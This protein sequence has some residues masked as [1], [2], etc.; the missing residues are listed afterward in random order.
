VFERKENTQTIVDA[1]CCQLVNWSGI[2]PYLKEQLVKVKSSLNDLRRRN[3]QVSTSQMHQ[4]HSTQDSYEERMAA[5]DAFQSLSAYD[6]KMNVEATLAAT[7]NAFQMNVIIF[8]G[9]DLQGYEYYEHLF[10]LTQACIF[11]ICEGGKQYPNVHW[12][13]LKQSAV[14]LL[15][16]DAQDDAQDDAHQDDTPPDDHAQYDARFDAPF[17]TQSGHD[18]SYE[19]LFLD[20]FTDDDDVAVVAGLNGGL[21]V[22]AGLDV[23]V[24]AGLDVAVVGGLDVAAVVDGLDGGVNLINPDNLGVEIDRHAMKYDAGDSAF[25]QDVKLKLQTEFFESR[26]EQ[27]FDQDQD[28]YVCS[29]SKLLY[30]DLGQFSNAAKD[31]IWETCI[32]LNKELEDVILHMVDDNGPSKKLR[33]FHEFYNDKVLGIKIP[34]GF[35]ITQPDLNPANIHPGK[36]ALNEAEACEKRLENKKRSLEEQISTTIDQI[37]LLPPF[38]ALIFENMKPTKVPTLPRKHHEPLPQGEQFDLVALGYADVED[39]PLTAAVYSSDLSSIENIPFFRIEPLGD[40][41]EDLKR[42]ITDAVV[43]LFREA[44]GWRKKVWE[45]YG[46]ECDKIR[47]LECKSEFVAEIELLYE[48]EFVLPAEWMRPLFHLNRIDLSPLTDEINTLPSL[49][50]SLDEFKSAYLYYDGIRQ[51]LKKL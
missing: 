18:D 48:Q 33:R 19:E 9:T 34:E 11:L 37:R 10:P 27:D 14:H 5:F 17:D 50:E 38:F 1:A 32:R 4:M 7:R 8:I 39:E 47:E 15:G 36:R 13:K 20:G 24:V 35:T 42:F 6:V 45:K 44:E 23:A 46:P 40:G 51:D 3:F 29:F 2:K 16:N 21:D 25:L 31:Y 12:L 26:F 43:A 30:E 49:Q 41:Y 22:A 28:P